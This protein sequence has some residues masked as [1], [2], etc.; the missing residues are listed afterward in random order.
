M[1]FPALTL[2]QPWATLCVLPV[3]GRCTCGRHDCGEPKC[4]TCRC[5][6]VKR[7][8]TRSFPAPKTI[9]GRRVWMHAAKIRPAQ[10]HERHDGLDMTLNGMPR[11]AAGFHPR[12]WPTCWEWTEWGDGDGGSWRWVG[13]LGALVGSAVIGEPLPIEGLGHHHPEP[14]DESLNHGEVVYLLPDEDELILVNRFED[15]SP[16]A[17][18]SDQLPYGDWTPGRWAW[19]LLD[20]WPLTEPI[21]AKG[22]QGVWYTDHNPEEHR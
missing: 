11:W 13:P 15:H 9:I 12:D 7:F 20:V 3:N 19:P 16:S 17:D 21:P 14:S 8:E 22:A 4:L 6:L 2:H 1:R 18:I 5:Q 10:I